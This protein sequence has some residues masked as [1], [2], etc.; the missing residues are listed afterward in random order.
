[1]HRVLADTEQRQNFSN[2]LGASTLAKA[3]SIMGEDFFRCYGAWSPQKELVS[4]NITLLKKGYTALGWLG[5]TIKENL[6]TGVFQLLLSYSLE[7]LATVG[8]TDYD[9][10]G[11][12]LKNIG[13]A[14]EAWGGIL[15]PFYTFRKR[16][17]E[18]VIEIIKREVPKVIKQKIKNFKSLPVKHEASDEN[19]S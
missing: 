8:C 3:F 2:K 7:D 9:F 14:K 13:K 18:Y 11:A 17:L 15:T 1:M 10:C 4:V 12:T 19:H 6:S 5:G 16:D